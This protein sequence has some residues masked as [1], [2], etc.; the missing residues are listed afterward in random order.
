MSTQD[1]GTREKSTNLIDNVMGYIDTRI[2]IIRLEIQEKLKAAFVSAIHGVLLGL[3][4]F[5]CLIFVSI[6]LG[7]LLNDALDSVFW[8]FGIV[9]LFY[10]ILLVILVVGLDKKVFQDVADKTFDNTLYKADKRENSI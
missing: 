1:N 3:V 6:F 2:D 4:G 5:M 7:L 8:G 10:I 9:A